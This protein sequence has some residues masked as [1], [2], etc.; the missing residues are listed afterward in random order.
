MFNSRGK[1]LTPEQRVFLEPENA[2]HRQDEAFRAF[3]VEGLSSEEAA[4]RFGYTPGSFRVLCSQFRQNLDR[5]FFISPELGPKQSPKKDS[6]RE[7]VIAM[8]KQNLSVYDIARLLA[9]EGKSTN[10]QWV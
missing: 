9:E 10:R 2:T 3:F 6:V 8:R 4:K 7:R 1:R 5:P